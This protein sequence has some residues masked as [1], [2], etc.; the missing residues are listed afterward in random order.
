[1]VGDTSPGPLGLKSFDGLSVNVAH[2]V[3]LLAVIDPVMIVVLIETVIGRNIVGEHC[4]ILA[5]YIL[6]Q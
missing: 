3:E 1:M 6:W 5:E 4:S 2:D